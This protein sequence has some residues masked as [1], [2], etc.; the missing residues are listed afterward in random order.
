MKLCIEQG[1]AFPIEVMT[2]P[3]RF[4]LLY[5]RHTISSTMV[6]T[7]TGSLIH[8]QLKETF[9][10]KPIRVIGVLRSTTVSDW[11]FDTLGGSHLQSL[12]SWLWRW[13]PY[14]L[15]KRHSLTTVL[16]R[17]PVTQKIFF[18]QGMLLLGSNHFLSKKKMTNKNQNDIS[19]ILKGCEEDNWLKQMARLPTLAFDKEIFTIK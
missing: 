4:H 14:R 12:D 18:N 10:E 3:L 15:S 9:I 16:L 1:R 7:L 11:H 2:L 5:W 13:L 8:Q 6:N 19:S 17:T